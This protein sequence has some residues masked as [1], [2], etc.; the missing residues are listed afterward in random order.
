MNVALSW[1]HIMGLALHCL[2][3]VGWERRFMVRYTQC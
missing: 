2:R 3:G 1:V